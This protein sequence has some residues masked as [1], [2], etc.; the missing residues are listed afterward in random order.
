M[1]TFQA[2]VY[3]LCLIT[4]VTCAYLLLR[5]WVQTRSKLLLWSTLCFALLAINNF[6]VVVDLLVLPQTDLVPLRQLAALAAIGA[7][8]Y[9]FIWEVE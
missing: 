1:P 9:G 2:A 4:S 5:S 3:L 6:L 8:I 7:L